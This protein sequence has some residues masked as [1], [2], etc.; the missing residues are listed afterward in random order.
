M[1]VKRETIFEGKWIRWVIYLMEMKR[2][3]NGWQKVGFKFKKW[4]KKKRWCASEW[5]KKHFF[6]VSLK[7]RE[8]TSEVWKVEKLLYNLLMYS[9]KSK[10][11]F[12]KKKYI[13]GLPCARWGLQAD[14]GNCLPERAS[15]GWRHVFMNEKAHVFFRR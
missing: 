2:P 3:L 5:W 9:I 11:L 4:R 8:R 1:L 10:Y 13:E 7:F 15:T 12:R 14:H 6:R